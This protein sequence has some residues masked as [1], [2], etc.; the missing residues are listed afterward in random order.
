MD[1][2]YT[3]TDIYIALNIPKPSGNIYKIQTLSSNLISGYEIISLASNTFYK[4]A[5]ND[6]SA[7]IQTTL[8][9]K[10]TGNFTSNPSIGDLLNLL[11]IASCYLKLL[12]TSLLLDVYVRFFKKKK[13]IKILN[14]VLFRFIFYILF[15]YTTVF[16]IGERKDSFL[17]LLNIS[18][19]Q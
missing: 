11:S 5:L 7:S 18:G 6:T 4:Y 1:R 14:F 15:F 19:L 12:P 13:I 10:N 16:L 2:P 17:S 8:I 9:Y 3:Y